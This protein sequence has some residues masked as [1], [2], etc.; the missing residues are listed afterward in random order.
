MNLESAKGHSDH[1]LR[2]GV[3]ILLARIYYISMGPNRRAP[4][5][6]LVLVLVV[7]LENGEIEDEDEKEDEHDWIAAPPR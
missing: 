3:P 5:K 2:N 1:S 6:F 7:V 4:R